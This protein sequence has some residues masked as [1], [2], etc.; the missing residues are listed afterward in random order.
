MYICDY[1]KGWKVPWGQLYFAVFY[2]ST[3]SNYN[4]YIAG[5]F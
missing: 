3:C 1:K 5:P 4:F 2:L